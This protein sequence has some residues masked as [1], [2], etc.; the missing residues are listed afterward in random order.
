M[1][2]QTDV[3]LQECRFG[4]SALGLAADVAYEGD[5]GIQERRT[6]N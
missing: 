6:E 3:E 1:S 2:K 5:A 4:L